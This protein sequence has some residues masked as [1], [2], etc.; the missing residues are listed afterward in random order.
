M[1]RVQAAVTVV[2]TDQDEWTMDRGHRRRVRQPRLRMVAL[3]QHQ[4]GRGLGRGGAQEGQGSAVTELH[5]HQVF[6][7]LS[8]DSELSQAAFKI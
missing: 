6:I 4:G 1:S 8:V 7:V 3:L 5:K 2:P